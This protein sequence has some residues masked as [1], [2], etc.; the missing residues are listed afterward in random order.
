MKTKQEEG[1]NYNWAAARHFWAA[2]PIPAVGI[3]VELNGVDLEKFL[4][5]HQLRQT[6]PH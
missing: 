3:V 2:I 6:F 5:R 4:Q 1:E